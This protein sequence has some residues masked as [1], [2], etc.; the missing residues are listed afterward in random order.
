MCHNFN[1]HFF[2]TLLILTTGFFSFAQNSNRENAPYSRYGIGELRNGAN[3]ALKGMA[4]VSSAYYNDYNVNTDNPASYSFLKYTTY[5]A[6]GEGSMRTVIANNKSYGTGTATLSYLTVGIPLGKN[7]GLAV[8]LRPV[9][10]V[11]YRMNDSAMLDGIG[12]AIRNYSGDGGTNYAFI[13]ASGVIKGFSVGVNV[14]Y[15]FG[16]IRHSSVLMKQ[17]DT[18]NTYNADFSKYTKIG[19]VYW[20]AGVLYKTDINKKMGL[21]LGGTVALVQDLKGWRDEYALSWRVAGGASI[22]DTAIN[23]QNVRG[24]VRLPMSYTLGAHLVGG[25]NWMVGADF[26]STNWSQY[27]SYD[28]P[29][30]LGTATR[31][32]I[33]AEVTPN[34]ASLY[35]YLQRVTYRMGFYYG[36]DMIK[37]RN[38]PVKYYAVTVGASLPFKRSPDRLHL[39]LDLGKRGT[40]TNGLVRENFFRFS[41]GI[42]LNDK[43]FVKR[44]YE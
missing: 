41:L 16:T 29:D 7:A 17:Y 40:E 35:K 6:G 39:A 24:E 12:P 3:T 27:R 15:M 26:S 42:S 31:I 19:G 9:T 13:G 2:L 18:V 37:L 28:V 5:E 4:T 44:K 32:A 38:T 20:K 22:S 33:G 30:S 21:R 25:E 43:W 36:T 1:K 10:K 11:F 8:G 34:P 23:N 14:G